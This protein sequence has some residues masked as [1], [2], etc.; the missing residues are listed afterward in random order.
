MPIQPLFHH[1]H[2]CLLAISA[3]P[4]SSARAVT[5]APPRVSASLCLTAPLQ[6]ACLFSGRMPCISLHVVHISSTVLNSSTVG[7]N[8]RRTLDARTQVCLILATANGRSQMDTSPCDPRSTVTLDGGKSDLL[9]SWPD[10]RDRRAC[11]T[12]RARCRRLMPRS[13]ASWRGPHRRHGL[14]GPFFYAV[15]WPA[16]PSVG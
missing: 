2:P 4:F 8:L 14:F 9:S 15:V 3:C 1:P 7:V 16:E 12:V 10:N 6:A 5:T 13:S 11:Y